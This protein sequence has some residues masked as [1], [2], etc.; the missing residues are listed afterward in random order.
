ML[1]A[2]LHIEVA[3]DCVV[4]KKNLVTLLMLDDARAGRSCKET[5]NEIGLD[6]ELII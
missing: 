4:Y 1:P 3:R 2:H 6:P 5:M